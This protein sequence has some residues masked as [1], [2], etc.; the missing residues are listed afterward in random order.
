MES[1]LR[2]F[3]NFKQNDWARLLAMAKFAYNNAKNASTGHTLF[4]LNCGYHPRML[5]KEEVNSCF[6]S[7]LAVELS[8]ELRELMIVCREISTTLKNFKSEPTT[9][10]LSLEAMPSV[11]KFGWIANTS[12]PKKTKSWK[13]SFLDHSKSYILLGSKPIN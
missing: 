3:V 13:Q 9:K 4:E 11:T 12:R 1:F 5:Y 2:A 6:K 7:K 8:A 10:A